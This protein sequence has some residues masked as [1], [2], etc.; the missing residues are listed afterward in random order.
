MRAAWLPFPSLVFEL[1]PQM[2]RREEERTYR[3][4]SSGSFVRMLEVNAAGLMTSL[5]GLWH[6]ESQSSV[7]EVGPGLQGFEAKTLYG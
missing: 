1:L 7:E 5:P 4:E 2:Y 6:A 3:Y